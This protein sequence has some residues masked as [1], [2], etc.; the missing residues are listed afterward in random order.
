MD[1]DR[2]DRGSLPDTRWFE[3]PVRIGPKEE[4]ATSS[5]HDIAGLSQVWTLADIYGGEA[6]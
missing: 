2:T 4:M 6:E 5:P 3:G 1:M